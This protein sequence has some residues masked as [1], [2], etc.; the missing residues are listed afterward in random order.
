MVCG[1]V[2]STAETKPLNA[3]PLHTRLARVLLSRQ[4][5]PELSE[6]VRPPTLDKFVTFGHC[7]NRSSLVGVASGNEE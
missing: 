1:G 5:G 2:G 7:P 4:P 6:V 3:S